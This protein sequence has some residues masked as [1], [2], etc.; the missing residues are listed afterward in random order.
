MFMCFH[1]LY[2]FQGMGKSAVAFWLAVVRQLILYMPLLLLMNTLFG[3]YGL[4]WT[5]LIGDTVMTG[6]SFM[7]YYRFERKEMKLD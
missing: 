2:F 6:I 4:V 5:Q 1:I 3:M 7:A